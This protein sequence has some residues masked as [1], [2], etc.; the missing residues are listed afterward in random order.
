M[1]PNCPDGN[2]LGVYF[3]TAEA[4]FLKTVPMASAPIVVSKIIR[5]VTR[6]V[7]ARVA[8]PRFDGYLVMVYLEDTIHSD[9]RSD[10]LLAPPRWCAKGT[11]CVVDLDEGVSAV[12]H[13]DL[14]S[15]AIYLPKALVREVGRASFPGQGAKTLRCRRAEP[16]KVVSNLASV[17]LSLFERDPEAVDPL[18]RHLSIALCAHL[19]Q[20]SLDVVMP[21]GGAI[22]PSDREMA[23]KG[24]MQENLARE[25]KVSEVAAVIGL[26]AAYFA[27]GF[28]NVTGLT[29][30]QW[31][32]QARIGAAKVLL[33]EH[34]LSIKEIAR[35][36]GFVD[37][38]H[39]TKVFSREVGTTPARWRDRQLH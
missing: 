28:K 32:T 24:Y 13:R 27:Q 34:Q 37:Q 11:V 33:S 39:F 10:G 16:D 21:K 1:N 15:L 29:P 5:S 30:R 22:L 6:D 25:L 18:L 8:I 14:Y 2:S 23:V 20:D 31:L 7:E 3:G 36:C 38:S 19:L 35:A 17:V 26:S 12:L 4:P 9:V